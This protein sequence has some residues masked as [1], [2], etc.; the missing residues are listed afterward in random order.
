M[1]QRSV[2]VAADKG[3][4]QRGGVGDKWRRQ[5]GGQRRQWQGWRGGPGRRLA[6]WRLHLTVNGSGYKGQAAPQS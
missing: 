3:V 5:T 1:G 6:G 2:E 4:G